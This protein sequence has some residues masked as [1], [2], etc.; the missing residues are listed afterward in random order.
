MHIGASYSSAEHCLRF[1]AWAAARASS[2]GV[3]GLT[4]ATVRELISHHPALAVATQFN[5]LPEA[6]DFDRWH[7]NIRR[8]LVATTKLNGDVMLTHGL[9][10]KIIN[11]FLKAIYLSHFGNE[12]DPMQRSK[13]NAIHPPV[14]RLLLGAL[15]K[16]YGTH[17]AAW[18]HLEH[19]GWKSFAETDYQT[20]IDGIRQITAGRL[21]R[22]EQHWN[23]DP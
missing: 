15:G 23:P 9:A 12:K 4:N 7:L 2:R 20:A 14:D 5:G 18:R 3:K 6:G 10:A 17:G 16:A 22:I 21:W 11:V 8:D 19:Q 13:L 1:A